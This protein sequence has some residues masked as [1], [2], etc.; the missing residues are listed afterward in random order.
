M[1]LELLFNFKTCMCFLTKVIVI[2]KELLEKIHRMDL[3][4]IMLP[5]F[6]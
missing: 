3:Q 5:L 2:F 1:K 6:F 4:L